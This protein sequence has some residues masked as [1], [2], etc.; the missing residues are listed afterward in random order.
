M[1]RFR[2]D[3]AAP[4]R[5]EFFDGRDQYGDVLE[6]V[7]GSPDNGQEA[8]AGYLDSNQNRSIAFRLD[9]TEAAD[10]SPPTFVADR[11]SSH[12]EQSI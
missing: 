2:R 3:R 8:D 4:R 9:R 5:S 7:T 1:I 10:T 11:G 6:D 12:G